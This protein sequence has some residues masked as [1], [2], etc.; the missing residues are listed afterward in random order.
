MTLQFGALN[1]YKTW[2]FTL[3]IAWGEGY[4]NGAV[5][6]IQ[7]KAKVQEETKKI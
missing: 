7:T 4:E 5:R 3:K 2:Y 6:K 1:G